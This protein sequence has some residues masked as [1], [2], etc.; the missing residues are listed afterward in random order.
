MAHGQSVRLSPDLFVIE[1]ISPQRQRPEHENYELRT[2]LNSGEWAPPMGL[3]GTHEV[4]S[5]LCA[6]GIA[7]TTI[8]SAIED[9]CIRGRATLQLG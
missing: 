8:N 7:E 3:T 4:R 1:A 5:F 2:R 9:L 6:R